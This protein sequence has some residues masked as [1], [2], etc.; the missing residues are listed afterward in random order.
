MRDPPTSHLLFLVYPRDNSH[1]LSSLWYFVDI[2][3]L[4]NDMICVVKGEA[5]LTHQLIDET[6]LIGPLV[7]NKGILVLIPEDLL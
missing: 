7:V 2:L 5:V 3:D 1:R 4:L 6:Q